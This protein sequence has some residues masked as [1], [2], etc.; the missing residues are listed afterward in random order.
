MQFV[1]HT[2]DCCVYRLMF[3]GCSNLLSVLCLISVW[4]SVGLWRR[5]T[6]YI[7]LDVSE[8][9]YEYLVDGQSWFIWNVVGYLPDC[10]ASHTSRCL[11]SYCNDNVRS[12]EGVFSVS[13]WKDLTYLPSYLLTTWSTVL[14]EKLTGSQLV[15]KFPVFCGTWRF[16]TAFTSARHLSLSWANSIQSILPHPTSWR[17]ILILSSHLRLGLPSGLFPSGFPH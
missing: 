6:S 14:L 7:S 15:K 16:I 5:V 17:S 4:M 9:P 11:Q 13:K 10:T 8:E 2:F 12:H 3:V 1:S